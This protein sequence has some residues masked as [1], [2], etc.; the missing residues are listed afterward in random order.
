M[1]LILNA[2]DGA[3]AVI[4]K[5]GRI[6]LQPEVTE[7][8]LCVIVH[9]PDVPGLV[10]QSRE[11][12]CAN[13]LTGRAVALRPE[14]LTAVLASTS[15]LRRGCLFPPHRHCMKQRAPWSSSPLSF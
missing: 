14:P 6:Y 5:E 8:R 9:G 11:V 2:K 12:E 4:S 7:E 15:R 3:G 1:Q 13:V 10:L